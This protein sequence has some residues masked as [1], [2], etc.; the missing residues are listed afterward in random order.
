M[1]MLTANM[2]VRPRGY[3]LTNDSEKTETLHF[4]H[5]RLPFDFPHFHRHCF[6]GKHLDSKTTSI[7][8]MCDGFCH[9]QDQNLTSRANPTLGPNLHFDGDCDGDEEIYIHK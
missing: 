2:S 8:I 3:A 5:Q 1:D 4:P 6:K 9:Q 7:I